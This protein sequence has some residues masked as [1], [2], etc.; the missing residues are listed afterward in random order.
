[1]TYRQAIAR[2]A[3]LL[4]EHLLGRARYEALRAHA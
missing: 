4:R 1:M 2:Q 3:L